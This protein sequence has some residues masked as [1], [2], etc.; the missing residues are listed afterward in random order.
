M[1]SCE[2]LGL[3]RYLP[4]S[5]KENFGCT[6]KVRQ[7]ILVRNYKISKPIGDLMSEYILTFRLICLFQLVVV[8]HSINFLPIKITNNICPQNR[9]LNFL[10]TKT[11]S[12]QFGV[13][14]FAKMFLYFDILH[15]NQ[16]KISSFPDYFFIKVDLCA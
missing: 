7:L 4:T 11:C 9:I 10:V 5:V 3:I 6:N 12:Y 15:A 8:K 13:S 16:L 2:V 1:N 14:P